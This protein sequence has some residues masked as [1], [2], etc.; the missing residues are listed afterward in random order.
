MSAIRRLRPSF[1]GVPVVACLAVAAACVTVG[2]GQ[3]RPAASTQPA[4][5]GPAEPRDLGGVLEPLRE[6]HHLPALAAAVVVDGRLAARGAGGTR[7]S[8]SDV[9]VTVDDAFHIGSCTKSMTAT[10][11][12]LLVG[13]GKLAWDT[14]IASGLP[15]L[16]ND[17]PAEYHGV[18]LQQLLCHRSGLPE[19]GEPGPIF[20]KLRMLHGDMRAQ[21]REAARLILN[22]P[23]AAEP[24]SA[25]LYS[26]YGYVVAG[27]MAEHAADTDWEQM[28]RAWLFE[29]LGMTTAGFGPPG[30]PGELVQPCGHRTIQ[31]RTI[32]LGPGP[33]ADNPAVLG[34]AGTVHCS[35]SDWAKYALLH[36]TGRTGDRVLLPPDTLDRLHTDAFG[37]G[38]AFGWGLKPGR[39]LV[40]QHAGSNTLWFAFIRIM[41]ER[42]SAVLVA[43]NRGDDEGRDGCLAAA[44]ALEREFLRP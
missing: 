34:P 29:P 19:D 42:K 11:C 36:C 40:L 43:T 39:E 26:N 14:T 27:A 18:T 8:D 20:L 28:M 5:S 23:P 25:F 6:K 44:E 17:I 33:L 13:Q 30:R 10:I 32:S 3:S 12:A 16:R 7:Q 1:W 2:R 35:L 41:P 9:R 4:A 15:H 21:R 38:Y 31:G 37:Q 24:G 22:Q